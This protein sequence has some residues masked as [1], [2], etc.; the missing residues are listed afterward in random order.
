MYSEKIVKESSKGEGEILVARHKLLLDMARKKKWQATYE[1]CTT[2]TNKN[3]L[4]TS[5]ARR[6]R[7]EEY[8]KAT[9]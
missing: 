5:T 6:K 9:E 8:S 3:K 7:L 1:F 4:P 2:C